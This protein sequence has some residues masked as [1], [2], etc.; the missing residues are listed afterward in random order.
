MESASFNFDKYTQTL[1]KAIH[2]HIENPNSLTI[3]IFGEWGS[4]KSELLKCIKNRFEDDLKEKKEKPIIPIF[5]NVWRYEKEEHLIIPLMKTVY[6]EFEKNKDNLDKK[7]FPKVL[8]SIKRVSL[9]L[10]SSFEFEK[11]GFKISPKNAIESL[12]KSDEEEMSYFDKLES[13][14]YNFQQEIEEITKEVRFAFLIDDLDRCLPENALKMFESIKLFLDVKG[15]SFVIAVDD[16]VVERGVEHRYK[17]YHF[18]NKENGK[19]IFDTPIN[20]SEYLEKMIQLPFSLPLLAQDDIELFLKQNYDGMFKQISSGQTEKE[21]EEK[22]NDTLLK[23]F[24]KI[25]PPI[26]RKIERTVNL[27]LTKKDIIKEIG[28]PHDEILLLKLVCLELFAP[29]IYRL[30][31]KFKSFFIFLEKW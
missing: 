12:E 23:L 9:S 5:F 30:K 11:F 17:D 2:S 28:L 21:Q 15:C 22:Y 14:Y 13:P 6:Y 16:D 27:Y 25:V 19:E 3:G 18:F 20:G 7:I 31:S 4:G 29:K 8:N 26:P 1:S 24:I 10:M